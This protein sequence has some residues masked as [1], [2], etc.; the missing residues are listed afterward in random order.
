MNNLSATI[1]LKNGNSAYARNLR[2]NSDSILNATVYSN[3][4]IHVPISKVSQASYK[5]H[6]LGVPFGSIPGAIAGFFASIGVYLVNPATN[7]WSG[8]NIY[9]YVGAPL[10]LVV[11]AI[12]GWQTGWTYNYQFFPY[13]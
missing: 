4:Y 3:F 2:I 13:N 1:V 7:T 5:N 8:N 12:L 10:G 11:G 6:W 9:L